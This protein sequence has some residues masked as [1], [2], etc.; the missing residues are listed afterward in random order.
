MSKI[1]GVNTV[2]IGAPFGN[3]MSRAG[4]S[5]T[6]GTF[7]TY[8]RG[9]LSYRIWRMV[10]TLRYSFATGGWV[11][12]LGIPNPGIDSF[13]KERPRNIEDG[14]VGC[15]DILSIHGFDKEDWVVISNKFAESRIRAFAVELNVSCPNVN[16]TKVRNWRDLFI[17][18]KESLNKYQANQIVVKIPPINYEP[19]VDGAIDASIFNFHCCNTLPCKGGGMSGP[20]L[21][22][23]SEQ[24]IKY[25]RRELQDPCIIAGGGILSVPD[26]QRYIDLGADHV[27]VGSALLNPLRWNLPTKIRKS[28]K[29]H[30]EF[31]RDLGGS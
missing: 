18:I 23:F 29:G 6:H 31:E 15:C 7:T 28:L 8:N 5:S 22:Q 20:I 10:K 25:V 21:R 27:A 2:I 26:A 30:A 17:T 12:K 11:N 19:V 16:D 3:Y 1:P 14:V 13:I 24:A 9:G 4:C